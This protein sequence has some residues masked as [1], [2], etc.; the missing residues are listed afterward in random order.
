MGSKRSKGVR[1]GV[2]CQLPGKDG[3]TTMA[4]RQGTDGFLGKRK[5][6]VSLER[7]RATGLPFFFASTDY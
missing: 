1:W 3:G 7:K 6:G 4:G 5:P 2:R